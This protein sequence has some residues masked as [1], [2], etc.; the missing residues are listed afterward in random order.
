MSVHIVFEKTADDTIRKIVQALTGTHVHTEIVVT[1][2]SPE[3][4]YIARTAYAAYMYEDFC[5]ISENNFRYSDTT[6]DFLQV[7]VSADEIERIKKTCD[8]RV[9]VKTPYNLKDM[10]LSIIPLRNPTEKD[11]F[12]VKTL[13][14][15]QSIVLILRSCLEPTHP[16]LH[17][18]KPFNSRT[19]CPEQLFTALKPVC[20]PAQAENVLKRKS[21]QKTTVRKI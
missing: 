16:V 4:P 19:I 21:V 5:S 15:S 12:S 2:T 10:V 6:H 20:Q 13:Y 18:L 14:C 8:S 11:I 1:A 7:Y 3:P 17:A 9:R